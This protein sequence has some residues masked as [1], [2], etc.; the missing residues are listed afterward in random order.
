MR[1]ALVGTEGSLR[2]AIAR[3]VSSEL[4][5]RVFQP[6]FQSLMKKHG[7]SLNMSEN[8]PERILAYLE[9]ITEIHSSDVARNRRAIFTTTVVDI[10]A[11][12][13]RWCAQLDED[14]GRAAYK[15]CMEFT[16]HYGKILFC[17][18]SRRNYDKS[19]RLFSGSLMEE[20]AI[21]LTMR[22]FLQRWSVDYSEIYS[23]EVEDGIVEAVMHIEGDRITGGL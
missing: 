23:D 8:P 21:E 11:Y 12:Y 6:D 18:L 13:F 9:D 19:N 10:V 20:Y 14:I 17:R 3:G 2:D 4:G 7:L 16:K 5:I 15:N 1:V 22:G